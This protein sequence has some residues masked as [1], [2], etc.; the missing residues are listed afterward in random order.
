MSNVIEI[1]RV[2]RRWNMR[3]RK[4]AHTG[5]LLRFNFMTFMQQICDEC[6]CGC[7]WNKITVLNVTEGWNV[8]KIVTQE[9]SAH[10][11]G[12]DGVAV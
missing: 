9:T 1:H 7:F 3:A 10:D 2:I 6:M 12:K 8:V 11:E 5:S 4:W